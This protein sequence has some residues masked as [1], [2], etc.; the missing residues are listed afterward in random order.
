MYPRLKI[1]RELLKEDGVIFISID[2][3]EQANLKIICD[4]IFGEENFVGDIVWNGQSGA[5]D[6]GFLRNNKEF[7]LIYAK[8]VNLFNVGLKDKENQKFNLY[9]DKRK[10]RYKRQLLRK[11]GDNSRREDRQNLYY[12]IKDNKGNDFYPTLPNGDDGCW[13]WS[14]FTMQQAINND[15]VEFAKARDGRIEA[16]EKIYESDENRKTQKYRT[17]ET[18]IGSS[19]T[20]TK[21]I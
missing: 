4:E 21:H 7:F 19:S 9:D 6:D 3:N 20:G 18:D 1:A 13:R 14:T 2:D 11:G 16:Y 17:L 15:I 5:E 10:E 8:N 12:P